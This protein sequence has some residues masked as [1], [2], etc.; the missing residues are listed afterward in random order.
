MS[1]CTRPRCRLA[2]YG[3][4]MLH[5]HWGA[6]GHPSSGRSAPDRASGE[7]PLVLLLGRLPSR[8]RQPLG[9]RCAR[10]LST[11]KRPVRT[12]STRQRRK[13]AVHGFAVSALASFAPLVMPCHP[14][15]AKNE[16]AGGL[17]RKAS[18]RWP[19]LMLGGRQR[20]GASMCVTPLM[21]LRDDLSAQNRA[22]VTTQRRDFGRQ[23]RENAGVLGSR[24]RLKHHAAVPYSR[25]HCRSPGAVVARRRRKPT[26]ADCSGTSAVGTARFPGRPPPRETAGS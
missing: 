11:P 9:C 24:S 15:G 8:Q 4:D 6:M 7:E 25:P 10:M 14:D 23:Y 13:R 3:L 22:S 20:A 16:P 17:C 2:C 19:W 18:R 1:I 21:V 12:A 5:R 26:Q